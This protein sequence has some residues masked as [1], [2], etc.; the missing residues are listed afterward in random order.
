MDLIRLGRLVS[1]PSRSPLLASEQG[2][3]SNTWV[4]SA[5]RQPEYD[6]TEQEYWRA[7]EDSILKLEFWDGQIYAMAGATPKHNDISLNIAS[8]LKV[9]LRGKS[10]VPRANDQRVKAGTL[11]TYPDVVVAC[12]PLRYDPNDANTLVDAA[13]IV[14]VLSRSTQNT[15]RRA[16]FDAYKQLPSLRH[17][18]LVAQNPFDVVH[19]FLDGKTWRSETL[20]GAADIVRLTAIDCQLSLDEIYEDIELAD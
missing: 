12:R 16:K 3:I 5:Q 8:S 11:Q 7:V 14:E 6:Y 10:C 1:R 9:Q 18:L 19:H 17:Y 2:A 13:V 15:D 20:T 4:M